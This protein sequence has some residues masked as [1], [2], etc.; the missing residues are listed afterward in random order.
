MQATDRL[1]EAEPLMRQ[2]LAIWEKSLGPDH[3]DV[4]IGLNN[5]ANLLKDTNLLGE[6]EPLMRRQLEI[7]LKFTKTTGHQH[8]YLQAAIKNYEH[9]L[10]AMGR[11]REG[12]DA[13]LRA[14]APE[15]FP[16]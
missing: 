11:T 13:Q 14:M 16:K 9:L 6:A 2:A 10:K 12:I 4:A 5:L 7:F 8:P 15:F 3:P 1:G